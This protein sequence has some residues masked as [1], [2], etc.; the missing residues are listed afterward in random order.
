MQ[1]REPSYTVDGNVTWRSHYGKHRG[2]S[3]KKYKKDTGTPVFI[4]ALL[5]TDK[6]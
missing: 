3:F 2:N 1:K 5:M 4:A 6:L